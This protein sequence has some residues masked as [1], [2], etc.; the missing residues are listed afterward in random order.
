VAANRA[1]EQLILETPYYDIAS[2]AKRYFPIYPE[3]H[4]SNILFRFMTI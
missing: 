2:L 3:Q 1:C 4:S